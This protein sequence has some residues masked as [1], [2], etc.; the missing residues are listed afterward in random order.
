[1]VCGGVLVTRQHALTTLRCALLTKKLQLAPRRLISLSQNN[2]NNG[3]LPSLPAVRNAS[4]STFFKRHHQ[5]QSASTDITV[6]GKW[7]FMFKLVR[8][9]DLIPTHLERLIMRHNKVDKDIP[10]PIKDRVGT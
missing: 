2:T 6:S 1:M 3:L 8:N 7:H 4:I 10:P 5:T 9:C